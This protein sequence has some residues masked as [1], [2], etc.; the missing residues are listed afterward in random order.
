MSTHCTSNGHAHARVSFSHP[1]QLGLSGE[2]TGLDD[3]M[4]PCGE[5]GANA[6]VDGDENG[7]RIGDD[8]G[9]VSTGAGGCG[10]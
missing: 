4:P 5:D 2:R 8:A 7:P 3:G 1:P 6:E 10:S 9:V